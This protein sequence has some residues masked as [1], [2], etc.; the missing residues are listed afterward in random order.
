MEPERKTYWVTKY[1]FTC[2]IEQKKLGVSSE[3]DYVRDGWNMYRIGRD[4]H[5]T[6]EAAIAHAKKMIAK[7]LASL[8]KQRARL[9]KLAE[10]LR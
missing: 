4:A 6:E 7:K 5:E 9:Q 1:L 3:P 8:D 2:G 10:E